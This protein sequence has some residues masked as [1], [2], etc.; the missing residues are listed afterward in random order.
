MRRGE[1]RNDDGKEKK[2]IQSCCSHKEII[3]YR[4]ETAVLALG[5]RGQRGGGGGGALALL[6]TLYDNI[7]G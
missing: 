6:S 5:W 1:L 3:C 7:D 2:K 4:K